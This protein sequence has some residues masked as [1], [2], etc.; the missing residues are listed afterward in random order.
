MLRQTQYKF[1]LFGALTDVRPRSA[2]ALELL[3]R[4]TSSVGVMYRS[5][6]P[7]TGSNPGEWRIKKIKNLKLSRRC[8][9]SISQ[10][11]QNLNYSYQVQNINLNWT[12]NVPTFLKNKCVKLHLHLRSRDNFFRSKIPTR[13]L[14][15]AY[16]N[17][18][19]FFFI[20]VIVFPSSLFWVAQ[21]F[22]FSNSIPEI[23]TS[24]KRITNLYF[25]VYLLSNALYSHRSYK[26]SK[27]SLVFCV[28]RNH[29]C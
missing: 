26:V 7:N 24:P 25:L 21:H 9:P 29:S 10:Y 6:S 27:R 22:F 4:A 1:Q 16:E 17:F 18:V 23:T 5:S 13:P 20:F 15:E 12:K 19:T 3:S 28:T 11:F 8:A 2:P 14:V